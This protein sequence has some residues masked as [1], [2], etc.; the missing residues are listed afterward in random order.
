MAIG[1]AG[2]ASGD[3]KGKESLLLML[4]YTEVA[5]KSVVIE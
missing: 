5:R 1:V 3:Y 2:S 4:R